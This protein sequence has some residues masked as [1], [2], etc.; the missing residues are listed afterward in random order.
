MAGRYLKLERNM[1]NKLT[2]LSFFLI[3]LTPLVTRGDVAEH[4][5]IRVMFHHNNLVRKIYGKTQQKIDERLCRAAQNHAEYMARYS[6]MSHDINGTPS[7]RAMSFGWPNSH[8]R[9][10]I[11]YGQISV[12]EIFNDWI[13]SPPHYKSMMSE[14]DFCGFGLAYSEHNVIYWCAV[15]ARSMPKI[16]ENEKRQ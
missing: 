11:G 10:N 3:L 16:A 5:T 13:E 15:Y 6:N 12:L 4:E 9:E 7:L 1:K 2:R 8:V 14:C